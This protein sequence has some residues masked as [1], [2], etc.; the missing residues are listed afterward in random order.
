MDNT[1]SNGSREE[2]ERNEPL[3]QQTDT[4]QSKEDKHEKEHYRLAGRPPL[5]TILV[6][7]VGPI[8]SQ[9]TSALYGVVAT[10]WVA[11]AVGE[12]GLTAIST[13]TAF[14]NIGRSFGFFVS[15]AG[16]SCISGL[17]GAG[18]VEEAGQVVCD[19]LRMC[20]IFGVLVPAIMC[21][22]VKLGVRWFG[23]PEEI[24]E[25]GYDYML[26]MLVTTVTQCIFV[27]VGGFLQG[28]GRS[29]LYGGITILSSVLNMAVFCPIFLLLCK[30]GMMGAGLATVL[31]EGI[32]G[33]VVMVLFF[34]GKFA[35]K[36]KVRQLF[37]PFSKK[38]FVAL[39]VG[40]SQLIANLSVCAPGI[41]VRKLLGLSS[42][43]NEFND[44]LAGFNAIFRYA[45]ITNNVIIAFTMGFLPA[46][47]YAFS[48]K[49]WNRWMRLAAHTHW[50]GFV[51]GSITAIFTWTI[52]REIAKMFSSDPNYLRWAG[53]MLKVGNAFGFIVVAR[54][55][56]PSLLQ[57]MKKGITSTL[58]SLGS[59]L[60]SIIAFAFILYYTDKK[61]PVRL[62]WCY[63]LSYAFG[64]VAGAVVLLRPVRNIWVSSKEQTED[65]PHMH[66]RLTDDMK[67]TQEL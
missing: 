54:F 60:V 28:E 57:S 46:A 9:I 65:S 63:P 44:V 26:P 20:C 42:V 48:A 40:L 14:D 39:R 1:A 23:A 50:L 51:W 31:A 59:Q 33:L 35:V 32:P 34:M 64:L 62:I 7:S 17:F 41:I 37:Q 38:T 43:E 52:P 10:I 25:M 12:K 18:Q 56:F 13:Y 30:M 2:D 66:Q 67:E 36:P 21:P 45:Q 4:D 11:K 24:V 22:T 53:P 58:L 6:L 3:N 29:M 47:S 61:N 15:V 8:L 55:T 19:L 27:G 5:M 16:S 49:M